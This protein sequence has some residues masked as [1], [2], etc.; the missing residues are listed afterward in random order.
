MPSPSPDTATGT[1]NI[2]DPGRPG[3]SVSVSSGITPVTSNPA[4]A[5]KTTQQKIASYTYVDKMTDTQTEE[6]QMQLAKAIYASGC[7]LSMVDNKLWAKFFKTLRPSFKIPSR[8]SISN[9]LLERVYQECSATVKELVA[10][11]SSVAV[12]CDGW[13]NIRSIIQ[14]LKSVCINKHAL[15][16][17]AINDDAKPSLDSSIRKLLL[18]EV[19]WDRTEGILKLLKPVADAITAIE[20]DNKNLSLVMKVFSDL[21]LSFEENLSSSPI[22][23]SEED[24]FKKIIPERKK[25]LVKS[26]HL[27]ANL[28]DPRYCGCHLSGEEAVD[29]MQAIYEIAAQLPNVDET[30]IIAELADY[31]AAKLVFIG[32]NLALGNVDDAN[33]YPHHAAHAT[34]PP[35]PQPSTSRDSTA[36]SNIPTFQLGDRLESSDDSD[37]SETEDSEG[38]IDDPIIRLIS[39][40][41]IEEPEEERQEPQ[42][43]E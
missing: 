35:P 16:A 23:K 8:D 7:P 24:A 13:T 9:N 32:Q 43:L 11:A 30:Q 12:M 10:S 26:I 37:H 29:A 6:A 2:P 41:D 22:L 17:L 38:S 31:R 28:V 39:S 20:G 14:C 15:Q 4:K 36:S 40:S 5:K 3:S 19:F 1:T 21:K 27:A 25:F 34:N 33:E 42:D 18:S